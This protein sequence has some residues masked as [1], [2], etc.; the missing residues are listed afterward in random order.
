MYSF[1]DIGLREGHDF[2][3]LSWEIS[4]FPKFCTSGERNSTAE[5]RFFITLEKAKKRP[6]N[7]TRKKNWLYLL[8][9]DD[10]RGT[11][12]VDCCCLMVPLYSR[13][14]WHWFN[15]QS[16]RNL[17][18]RKLFVS[19]ELLEMY[20]LDCYFF[21]SHHQGTRVEQKLNRSYRECMQWIAI[22]I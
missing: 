6:K 4:R 20:W 18:S 10:V 9:I 2:A 19:S 11:Q 17:D 13:K 7:E 8:H 22:I 15:V 14:R 21:R 3:P 5:Y 1:I 16:K 12:D